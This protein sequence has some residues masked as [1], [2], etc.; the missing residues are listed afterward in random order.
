MRRLQLDFHRSPPPT[1]W[2]WLLLLSGL[3]S[4]LGI[5][6]THRQITA[7]TASLQVDI[8]R[9]EARLP[10]ASLTARPADDGAL[11]AARR[12]VAQGRHPWEDLFAT[13]E[14][15][16]NKDVALLALAPEPGKGHLKIH[17]EARNLAAMLAYQRRLESGGAL[18]HVVLQE[19]D[20]ARESAEA[21]VRFH[22]IA[23]WGGRRGGP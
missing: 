20:I 10:G 7:E 5:G 21:P 16:D 4:L 12:A 18:Q 14:A 17:A 13:L 9:I 1:L 3:G 15:A 11:A 6:A 8:R 2:S 23:D 19:H 22:I